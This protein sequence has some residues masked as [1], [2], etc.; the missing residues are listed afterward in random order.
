MEG[1][2][3]REAWAASGRGAPAQPPRHAC[4]AGGG[5]GRACAHLGVVGA[6]GAQQRR[7]RLLQQ[8]Q[9]RLQGGLLLRGA[10]QQ[11]A[12][13]RRHLRRTGEWGERRGERARP[14][15]RGPC[16]RALP[17]VRHAHWAWRA[18]RRRAAAV[19]WE[20][21]GPPA[22]RKLR[23]PPLL[24]RPPPPGIALARPPAARERGGRPGREAWGVESRRVWAGGVWGAS[25]GPARRASTSRENRRLEWAMLAPLRPRAA[26]PISLG[27]LRGLRSHQAVAKA[28]VC[29]WKRGRNAKLE[30]EQAERGSPGPEFVPAQWPAMLA[31][32]APWPGPWDSPGAPVADAGRNREPGANHTRPH[33][34]R[35]RRR[36]RNRL[37]T[38][39]ELVAPPQKLL[40][41]DAPPPAW[42]IP[43]EHCRAF[44]PSAALH[45]LHRAPRKGGASV[46]ATAA[47]GRS[48]A[49]TCAL[50]RPSASLSPFPT[51]QGLV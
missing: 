43:G 30:G 32:A 35:N 48:A 23:S 5:G 18:G 42:C 33:P 44:T 8:L 47:L 26:R 21:Q 3:A 9:L 20:G 49:D 36:Q 37:P 27:V 11:A 40:V 4:A 38:A 45:A 51:S 19:G 34:A 1:R 24:G 46:Q 13:P 41:A 28:R 22:S 2:G 7:Q 17:A 39:P 16:T 6:G 14:R 25:G 15:R 29:A 50:R 10:R 12:V 31:S